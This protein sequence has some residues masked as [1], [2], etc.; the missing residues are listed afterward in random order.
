MV[1]HWFVGR[2]RRSCLLDAA[3]SWC[4]YLRPE[5][6][7][8]L[9]VVW[10]SSPVKLEFCIRKPLGGIDS[11]RCRSLSPVVWTTWRI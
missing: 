3:A 11:K 2:H 7:A 8:S 9:G 4:V 1:R 10:S 5:E 6:Q